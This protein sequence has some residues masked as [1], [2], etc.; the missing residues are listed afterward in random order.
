MTYN[1]SRFRRPAF[2]KWPPPM[3]RP[4]PPPLREG[5][6]DR[7]EDAEIAASR[8]PVVVDLRREVGGLQ[9]LLKRHGSTPSSWGP[10]PSPRTGGPRRA[11]CSTSAGRC[12]S[13]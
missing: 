9:D 7:P 2:T 4:P 3:P 6:L 5:H 1:M 8:A 10:F 12:T 13:G 11:P